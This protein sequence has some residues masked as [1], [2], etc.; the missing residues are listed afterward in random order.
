ML[1]TLAITSAL[2]SAAFWA[3]ASVSISRFLASGQVSPA[4]ANLFKNTAA[5]FTFLLGTLIFGG[6][7]PVGVAWAWLFFSGF[8]GF[9]VADTL[10]FAAFQRCGVQ[11]AATVML[12]NVPIAT[13]LAL[14]LA[15]DEIKTQAIPFAV[16]V[17]VGVL[18]V[19]LDSRVPKT[20]AAS[21]IEGG[22]PNRGG[23]GLGVLLA[24][25]AAFAIGTSVPLGRGSFGDVSV[26]PGGFIR[27]AGGAVGAIPM[28]ILAGIRR[29]STSANELGRLLEP[30]FAAPGPGSVWGR[31]SLFGV[32]CAIIGLGPYH[33]AQRELPSGIATTLFAST[34][35]FTLPLAIILGNRVGW[36]G[37]LGTLVGFL[38]VVGIL[39]YGQDR[40][41]AVQP[42]A[43]PGPEVLLTSQ[44][45]L[46][47]R[48]GGRKP[49]FVR[50]YSPAR[51][52]WSDSGIHP[53]DGTNSADSRGLPFLAIVSSPLAPPAAAS[54]VGSAGGSVDTGAAPAT[55]GEDAATKASSSESV[56][57]GASPAAPLARPE[58]SDGPIDPP[59]VVSAPRPML[60]GGSD[61]AL[62]VP[63]RLVQSVDAPTFARGHWA[64]RP[65]GARLSTGGLLLGTLQSLAGTDA[66]GGQDPLGYGI[67][68]S[69]EVDGPPALD[70]G[71][72]H[73]D[74]SHALHG[75]GALVPLENGGA[76]M[77]WVDDRGGDQLA[78]MALYRRS[79]SANGI[80]DDEQSIDESICD[81]CPPDM[82]SLD[83]GTLLVAY[84]HRSPRNVRD[85]YLSRR[86]PRE[87]GW[88]QP[89]A[90]HHDGW[91]LDGCPVNGPALAASRHAVAVAWFTRPG[92]EAEQ[93]LEVA[94]SRD[95]GRTFASPLTV[96]K[97]ATLGRVALVALEASADDER[98]LLVHLAVNE[99]GEFSGADASWQAAIVHPDGAVS[100]FV[101]LADVLGSPSSGRLDLVLA[102]PGL[103]QA[104]WTG[105]K[106]LMS[107]QL[108]CD[109][110][111]A[112]LA[113]E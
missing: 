7:W 67:R 2:L 93:R 38:G 79:I 43:G 61:S 58:A 76:E 11:T 25:V 104:V 16:V 72:L 87:G 55:S 75:F 59:V 106:G 20:S 80:L 37:V 63:R 18:L 111:R 50:A 62:P 45:S 49:S 95:R 74:R 9:A 78:G 113:A 51:E 4:A 96:V 90:V 23:Y 82:I 86:D 85:I 108:R 81:C 14:P 32:G 110:N 47:A 5:A 15:G 94:F 70:L 22:G 107:A 92:D 60:F 40:P 73:G 36:K 102:G 27:L 88:S 19:I 29:G 65:F 33:Y 64:D 53:I 30:I 17:L 66:G 41:V 91:E 44:G 105:P 77:V 10:Y 69:L 103:A 83:D 3:L 48:Q 71:W 54:V 1:S 100:E 52:R 89:A 21:E 68:M 98:F 24:V 39:R 84:R 57:E 46:P 12:L 31:A 42:S 97:G 26:F 56:A 35:L 13:V 28:A 112:V 101:R 34:P 6:H 99:G 8:L 109:P